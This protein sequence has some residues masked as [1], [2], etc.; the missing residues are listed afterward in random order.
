VKTRLLL[1]AAAV[2]VVVSNLWVPVDARR[3][4]QT[5]SG[6]TLELSEDELALLPRPG[7]STVSLLKFRWR[8]AEE[9][10]RNSPRWLDQQK[11]TTLG[12]DCHVSPS[13]PEAS[14]HYRRLGNRPAWLVLTVSEQDQPPGGTPNALPTRLMVVDAGPDDASLRERYP[15][16]SKYAIVKG[17]VHLSYVDRNLRSSDA[18]TAPRLQ[19]RIVTLLPAQ[20]F[21]PRQLSSLLDALPDRSERKTDQTLLS[22]PRYTATVSWGAQHTPWLENLRPITPLSEA[23]SSP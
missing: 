11:L 22:A 9:D 23:D 19:G 6:G 16:L 15:D 12:F 3:N 4:Q 21:V 7:E 14:D 1:I 5:A 20:I 8:T 13:A 10:H 2:V 18:T 17:V